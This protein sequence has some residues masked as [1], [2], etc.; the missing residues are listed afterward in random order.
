MKIYLLFTKGV[1]GFIKNGKIYL[2]NYIQAICTGYD[3]CEEGIYLLEKEYNIRFIG[4][5]IDV[6]NEKEYNFIVLNNKKEF[7]D[8]ENI[9]L[10]LED[11]IIRLEML[12]SE[13]I[14]KNEDEEKIRNL[15][16]IFLTTEGIVP[17]LFFTKEDFQKGFL[18]TENKLLKFFNS[19]EL[20]KIIYKYDLLSITRSIENYIIS[21]SRN[22]IYVSEKIND[23]LLKNIKFL[24]ICDLDEPFEY[25]SMGKYSIDI[26]SL[27]SSIIIQMCSALDLISKLV[28]EIANFPCDFTNNIKFKSGNIYFKDIDRNIQK[29]RKYKGFNT[30]FLNNKKEYTDL[31]MIRNSIVHN[32]FFTNDESLFWGYK[33]N[34]VNK[35]PIN[36]IVS[37]VWDVD[38]DG[39][40]ERWLNRF[41]FYGQQREIGDYLINYFFKF[42]THMDSTIDMLDD[43]LSQQLKSKK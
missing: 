14:L 23:V 18:E 28:Y 30:S 13:V 11:K 10:N 33:N 27:Y 35:K 26:T 15:T 22:F 5:G 19:R 20:S 38:E 2:L 34:I 12:I 8:V 42:Y 40:P 37:Y 17:D 41:R 1:K 25:K 9:I 6:N 3:Y 24:N 43:Y 36:Y 32:A 31:I 16:P 21:F 39:K 7:L 4:T 29:Y